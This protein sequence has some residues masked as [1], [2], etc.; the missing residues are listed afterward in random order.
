MY[1]PQ[2]SLR[3]NLLPSVLPF[4]QVRILQNSRILSPVGDPQSSHFPDLLINRDYHQRGNQLVNQHLYQLC[5]HRFNLQN[6]QA[7]NLGNIPLDFR[8]V[9][10]HQCPLDDP[11]INLAVSL[12]VNRLYDR[13]IFLLLNHVIYRLN[14]HHSI[15]I[16]Y[17]Q[18]NLVEILLVCRAFNHFLDHLAYQT[19]HLQINQLDNQDYFLPRDLPTGLRGSP[20]VS[21]EKSHLVNRRTN[22]PFYL[23]S[24]L[25]LTALLPNQ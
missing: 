8:Q 10:L 25:S 6:Y 21:L 5:T 22:Q 2:N 20:Q 14:S 4:S 11:L 13:R 17:L 18:F 9:N 3:G 19:I 1:N 12:R 16:V 7:V 24:N 23:Q 15:R